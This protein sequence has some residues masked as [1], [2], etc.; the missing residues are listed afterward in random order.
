MY[1]YK[2]NGT[3]AHTYQTAETKAKERWSYVKR[4]RRHR[5]PF[6]WCGHEQGQRVL[7]S[8]VSAAI[9]YLGRSSVTY[10]TAL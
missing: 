1:T 3:E 10:Q 9:S 5:D 7:G 4:Q 6:Y 2:E 8:V